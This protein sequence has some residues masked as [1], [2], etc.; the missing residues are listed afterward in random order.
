MQ[1]ASDT[2]PAA[3]RSVERGADW[4][5]G[6]DAARRAG[7]AWTTLRYHCKRPG[8][9][10]VY[11]RM[12]EVSSPSERWEIER[13]SFEAWLA[14]YV[15]PK[16]R[17]REAEKRRA[18]EG[19]L[20]R[21]GVTIPRLAQAASRS[22][23]TVHRDLIRL[24]VPR[25]TISEAKIDHELRNRLISE[26]GSCG[27][28]TCRDSTCSVPPGSCHQEACDQPATVAAV[29]S[30]GLRH[31]A[32]YP[33]KFCSSTC[34]VLDATREIHG[35]LRQKAAWYEQRHKS[36]KLWGQTGGAPASYSDEH[37]EHVQQM[38]R[39][40]ASIRQIAAATGLKKGAVERLLEKVSRNP[41]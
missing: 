36:T 22:I 29:T 15:H 23:S 41:L 10:L 21:A 17:A 4:I 34:A 33:E 1:T 7:V 32:G 16:T 8:S 13:A 35:D 39:S 25:R 2:A 20:Y 11:R 14:D 31:V 30:S 38:R 5:S 24:D 6:V 12:R 9:G 3:Q 26:A 37:V 28:P 27:S 40:G 19:T 18:N